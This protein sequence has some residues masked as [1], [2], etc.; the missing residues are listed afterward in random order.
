MDAKDLLLLTAERYYTNA[1]WQTTGPLLHFRS[2][3]PTASRFN[4]NHRQTIGAIF[5]GRWARW[6][7]SGLEAIELLDDHE[8]RKRHNK[9]VDDIIYKEAV[10]ERRSPGLFC[11]GN[12]FIGLTGKSQE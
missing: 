12:R 1:L 6:R 8:D 4:R 10:V 2:A 3:V 11:F 5:R 9:K 7:W